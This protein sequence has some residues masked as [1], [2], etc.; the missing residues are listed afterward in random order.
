MSSGSSIQWELLTQVS[1]TMDGLSLL[2]VDGTQIGPFVQQQL[3]H[4]QNK[5]KNHLSH[6]GARTSP[7]ILKRLSGRLGY[8][9]GFGSGNR[10]HPYIPSSPPGSR[11]ARR[12]ARR[13]GPCGRPCSGCSAG[14]AASRR[15]VTRGWQP[16][17][18]AASARTCPAH[19]P[20][21]RVAAAG[22]RPSAGREGEGGDGYQLE[23][24]RGV[25]IT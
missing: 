19:W 14:S 3:H 7:I 25:R 1:S 12:G 16:P 21:P 11:S 17:R 8:G 9:S 18:A 23:T 4:L 10:L 6:G 24:G 13:C 20:P 5:T 15:S 22:P 2:L